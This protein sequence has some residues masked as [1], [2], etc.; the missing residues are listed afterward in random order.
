MFLTFNKLNLDADRRF[1]QVLYTICLNQFLSSVIKVPTIYKNVNLQNVV[2]NELLNYMTYS[3][4]S[5]R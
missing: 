5:V 3:V 2:P 4:K 1:N